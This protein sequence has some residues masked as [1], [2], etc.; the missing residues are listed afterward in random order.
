MKSFALRLLGC[1]VV[2]YAAWLALGP[3]G[4]VW[5]AP[6]F[7][8][9]LATPIFNA[10]T[11]A[12]AW[13]RALAYRDVEG[14]H[15]AFKGVSISVA[16]DDEGHLWLRLSDVR[17]VLPWLAR[18]ASLQQIFGAHFGSVQPDR[19]TRVQAEAFLAYLAR[20]TSPDAVPFMLWIERTVVYPS[21]RRTARSAR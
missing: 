19:A 14:R 20:R 8:I 9:A 12:W 10:V 6:L 17:K 1:C 21:K 3:Q 13:L 16:E 11:G 4:I 7:G 5:C 15:Y 18:D 2:T